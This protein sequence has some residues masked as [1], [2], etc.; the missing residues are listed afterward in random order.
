LVAASN[1]LFFVAGPASLFGSE[2][3]LFT[4]PTWRSIREYDQYVTR[5]LKIIRESFEPESTSILA[6]G[7]NFRL[8]DYYLS[9][10]QVPSLS[11]MIDSMPVKLTEPINTL[12]LFDDSLLSNLQPG[13]EVRSVHLTGSG[14]LN[15]F[16]WEPAQAV[17]VDQ[18]TVEIVSQ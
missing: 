18:N 12:V 9:D 8:P 3:M 7:R 10:Y 2:R 6:D 17:V 11:H 1:T 4:P 13:I 15:Y 5:R 16:V 14:V